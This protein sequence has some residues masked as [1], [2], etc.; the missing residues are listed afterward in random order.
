MTHDSNVAQ[1]Q[2]LYLGVYQVH[3]LRLGS[4]GDVNTSK[5]RSILTNQELKKTREKPMT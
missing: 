4:G 1:M 3:S 2:E 5:E